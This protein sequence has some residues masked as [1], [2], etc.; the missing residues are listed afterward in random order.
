MSKFVYKTLNDQGGTVLKELEAVSLEEAERTITARGDSPIWVEEK[1]NTYA[2]IFQTSTRFIK[3]VDLAGVFQ[4]GHKV[5]PRDLIIFFRQMASLFS[6]GVPLFE[7]LI[8]LEDQFS[9]ETFR[10]IVT[11]IKED[12]EAG[13]SFSEALAKYPNIFSRLVIAMVASGE[14]AG[15]M[16]ETLKRIAEYLEKE[17]KMKEKI[18]AALR[19]P[20]L[21]C[22]ALA[23]AFIVAI[24]VVIPQF[25]RMFGSLKAQLPLPTRIL[26]GINTILTS[27]WWLIIL[28]GLG[29]YILFKQ[30]IKRPAGRLTFDTLVLKLPVFG[31][32]IIKVSLSRFFSMFAAMES[33]SLTIIQKLDVTAETADNLVIYN[34]IMTMR[35]KVIQGLSLSDAMREHKLFPSTALHMIAIGEKAGNLD[36]MLVKTAVYFDEEADNMVA[37]LMSLMEPFI[38][39]FLGAF[40]A[41]L[42]AGI[43]L[44]MWSL[45]DAFRH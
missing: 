35:G 6:A 3:S 16:G 1:K 32:L 42:A 43:Y 33:S 7:S 2:N 14:R 10:K 44:P 45:M 15:V 4:R 36:D 41:L 31:S 30:F 40:V 25:A 13:L 22:I 19:Y 27:Y 23:S 29:A 37:D 18:G 24:L 38:I 28:V 39:L 11:K 8:A 17:R 21:V 26:I 12:V 9:D 20:M 34:I 5:R